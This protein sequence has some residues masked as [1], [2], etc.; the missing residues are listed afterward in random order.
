MNRL[1]TAQHRLR[2]LVSPGKR[3]IT[4]VLRLASSSERSSRFRRAQPVLLDRESR[5]TVVVAATPQLH[6]ELLT[7]FA[8]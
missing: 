3:P 7:A 2:Q 6:A 1:S 5:S 4:F 8:S